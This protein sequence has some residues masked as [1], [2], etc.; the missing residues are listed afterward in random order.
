MFISNDKK[1][2]FNT[3]YYKE[4]PKRLEEL[5]RCIDEDMIVKILPMH[6]IIAYDWTTPEDFYNVYFEYLADFLNDSVDGAYEFYIELYEFF[7]SI[8]A[9]ELSVFTDEEIVEL[10]CLKTINNFYSGFKFEKEINALIDKDKTVY[11]SSKQRDELDTIYK[12]DLEVLDDDDNLYGIQMK[13]TSYLNLNNRMKGY[14]KGCMTKYIKEFGAENCFF[15]FHNKDVQPMKERNTGSYLIP[16]KSVS[17]YTSK[18]FIIGSYEELQIE[19]NNIK[20]A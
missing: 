4:Y 7:T 15:L 19:L 8:M 12:I 2:L 6:N 17:D 5:G 14:H 20:K 3:I 16:Y 9:E 13:T 11:R 18:D 10:Y 1:T